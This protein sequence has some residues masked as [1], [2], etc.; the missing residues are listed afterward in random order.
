MSLVTQR[1]AFL[2]PIAEFVDSIPENIPENCFDFDN[3]E[4]GIVIHIFAV[5]VFCL[6][7]KKIV[8]Q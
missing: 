7:K 8:N 6:E 1:D 3:N 2:M 5:F 4:N